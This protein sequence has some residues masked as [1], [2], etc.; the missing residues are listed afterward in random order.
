MPPHIMNVPPHVSNDLEPIPTTPHPNNKP[1][2]WVAL[3]TPIERGSDARFGGVH[4]YGP[5]H[6]GPLGTFFGFFL[7]NWGLQPQITLGSPL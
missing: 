6:F 3:K 1:P 2:A 5:P 7:L 4:F